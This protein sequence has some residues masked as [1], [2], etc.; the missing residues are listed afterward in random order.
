MEF[1]RS[2]PSWAWALLF[3]VALVIVYGWFNRRWLEEERREA[4]AQKKPPVEAPQGERKRA[5]E[6]HVGDEDK[7]DEG[8]NH[9]DPG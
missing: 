3:I 4:E 2:I 6:L 9:V 5:A 8:E 7:E 1:L